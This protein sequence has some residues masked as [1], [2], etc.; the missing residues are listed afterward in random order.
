MRKIKSAPANLCL[1][2]N[3]KKKIVNNKNKSPFIKYETYNGYYRKK[4]ILNS[5]KDI[6]LDII[7]ECKIP[8]IEETLS[9]NVFISY[10]FE[11]ITKKDKLKKLSEYLYFFI[12]KYIITLIV[13]CSILHDMGDKYSFTIKYIEGI[14]HITM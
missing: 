1:M 2:A 9:I 11:N 4:N 7:G 6:T 14:A 12:V 8:S 10:F 13:H 5:I 3:N